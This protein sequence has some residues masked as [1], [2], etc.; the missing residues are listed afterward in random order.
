MTVICLTEYNSR[1]YA[2]TFEN[3]GCVRVQKFEDILENGKKILCV[4]SLRM[5][6]GESEF[7]EMT[8]LS[9]AKD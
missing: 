9:G 7:C 4:K 2:L 6:L 8:K 3:D 1:R 5:T